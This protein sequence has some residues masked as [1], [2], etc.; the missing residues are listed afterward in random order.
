MNLKG[1][2]NARLLE[3]AESAIYAAAVGESQGG[4]DASYDF[5]GEVM[6]ESK[7]RLVVAG[8]KESC[9]SGIYD[10]AFEVTTARH[11]GRV[12]EFEGCTCGA[13]R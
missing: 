7:R 1:M 3:V 12:P 9:R 8:H 13:G 11:G 2:T 6:A 10:R 5:A 4:D